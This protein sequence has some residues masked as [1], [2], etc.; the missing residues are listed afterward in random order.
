MNQ[1]IFSDIEYS[2]RARIT[3]RE[4]FLD[5]M[6]EIIPWEEWAG[7]V[8]PFYYQGKRGRSAQGDRKNA[9][10]VPAAGLVQ[11]IG[12]RGRRRDLRQLCDAEVYGHQFH[13]GRRAGYDHPVEVQADTGKQRVG[14]GNV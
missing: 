4:E 11:P 7:L 14:Q 13:G 5:T 2:G 8:Q 3:K 12:R 9:A 6:N 10:D 1:Q